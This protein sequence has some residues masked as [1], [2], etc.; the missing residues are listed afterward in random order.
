VLDLDST[1]LGTF[2]NDDLEGLEE[3]V[4]ILQETSDWA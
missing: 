4:R 1:V 3:V 2:D